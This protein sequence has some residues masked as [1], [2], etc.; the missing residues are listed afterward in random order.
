MHSTERLTRMELAK[1]LGV[2]KT[3]ICR[4]ELNGKLKPVIR[5]RGVRT[6]RYGD[7][8]DLIGDREI[9]RLDQ[10]R[11]HVPSSA[12]T[13]GEL[14]A[15]V[16]ELLDADV[17]PVDVVRKLKVN[18]DVVEALLVKWIRW[19]RAVLLAASEIHSY[20]VGPTGKAPCPAVQTCL[21]MT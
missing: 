21:P 5:E 2:G 7:V 15:A 3:T 18:A 11:R 8:A 16:F 6:F 1:T 14:N 17:H 12:G 9:V 10:A 19:R 20:S 4:W 13:S